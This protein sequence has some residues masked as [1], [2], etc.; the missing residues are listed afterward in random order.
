MN[1]WLAN[2]DPKAHAVLSDPF[3]AKYDDDFTQIP[4]YNSVRM[5]TQ[6]MKTA[7]STEPIAVAKAMEGVKINSLNGEIEMRKL[8]HQLLQQLVIGEW[9]KVNGK[10]VVFDLEKTGWGFKPLDRLAPHV[11]AMP[12]SCQMKRPG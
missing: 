10:D 7:K 12:T 6:A 3:K 1:Y 9:V 5:L 8:D 11:S 4:W 2:Q